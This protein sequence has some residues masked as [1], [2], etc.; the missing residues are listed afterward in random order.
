[1][2]ADLGWN[3]LAGENGDVAALRASLIQALGELD[4]EA[5]TNRARES[6]ATYLR[7][8]QPAHTDLQDAVLAVVAA[9][10]DA[11]QWAQIH[12]RASTS[13]DVREKDT[14]YQLLAAARDPK[15]AQQA[16]ELTLTDELDPTSRPL[17]LS[18]V[19]ETHPQL[20]FDFAVMHREQ[21][22]EWLEPGARDL[23]VAQLLS[24]SAD[25]AARQ[26]L[27]AYIEAHVPAADRRPAEVVEAMITDHIRVRVE[28]LPQI[29]AWLQRAH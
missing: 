17:M 16:L 24:T 5:V 23:F 1:M 13:R 15:L 12:Q 20:A 27:M 7:A 28:Q 19:A 3:P 21:V 18:T 8:P 4:D 22:N 25:P 2:F 9:H 14:F 10:A 6:F 26:R 11:M 29:D